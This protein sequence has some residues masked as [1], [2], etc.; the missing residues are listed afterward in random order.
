MFILILFG[1]S[2]GY[3]AH[4]ML[5]GLLHVNLNWAISYFEPVYFYLLIQLLESVANLDFK[6]K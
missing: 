5:P 2:L 4:I 3:K 1:H 6:I